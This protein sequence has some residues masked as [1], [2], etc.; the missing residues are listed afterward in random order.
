MSKID[1]IHG[2]LG[3]SQGRKLE[4]RLSIQLMAFVGN[5]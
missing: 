3:T 5:F 2:N 1:S 4:K